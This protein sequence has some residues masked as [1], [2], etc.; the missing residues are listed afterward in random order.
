[1][2]EGPER[3]DNGGCHSLLSGHYKAPP[4]FH[5]YEFSLSWK[6][7]EVMSMPCLR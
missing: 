4:A 6:W 7:C 3:P 2:W 1:M 5:N